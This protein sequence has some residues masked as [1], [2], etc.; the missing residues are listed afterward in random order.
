MP[1]RVL[2]PDS[3]WRLRIPSDLA[4]SS[5]KGLIGSR[6]FMVTIP[7]FETKVQNP[8]IN[9]PAAVLLQADLERPEKLHHLGTFVPSNQ[10]LRLMLQQQYTV[11]VGVGWLITLSDK[12]LELLRTQNTRAK[13]IL[14]ETPGKQNSFDGFALSVQRRFP[15]WSDG[16]S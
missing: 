5:L 6:I 13:L 7:W 16:R 12:V 11:D 8:R 3:K 9:F 15:A 14:L 2:V 4:I 1:W 10:N